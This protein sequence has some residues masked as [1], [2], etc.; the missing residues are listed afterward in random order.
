MNS[1]RMCAPTSSKSKFLINISF[2]ELHLVGVH[3]C[4]VRLN[5]INVMQYKF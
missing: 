1:E 3:M 5:A 2:I 4:S